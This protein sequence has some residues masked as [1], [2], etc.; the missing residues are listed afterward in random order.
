MESLQNLWEKIRTN[1]IIYAKEFWYFISSVLFL[2]NFGAMIGVASLFL[3]F[4]FWWM[5]CYTMHGDTVEVPDYT[6]LTIA[7]AL[8]HDDNDLFR[9]ELD[10]AEWKE[11]QIGGIIIEQSPK[12]NERVKENR[13]V[14]LTS[15]AFVPPLVQL[16]TLKGSYSFDQ[17]KRKLRSLNINLEI[18]ETRFDAKQDPNTIIHL[19]FDD[20]IISEEDLDKGVDIPKG[21]I[22]KCLVTEKGAFSVPIPN[23]VC[24]KLSEAEF[25]LL[26]S[27]LKLESI[28]EDHTVYDSEN[29]Y[30]YKQSPQYDASLR[31][32]KAAAVDLYITQGVP[33]G[34]QNI[35]EN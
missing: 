8:D 26:N 28:H 9:I 3:L 17:Y 14:Y 34:C 6:N 25:I 19:I 2:K 33:E 23:L 35:I 21:S 29:A 24:Q 1:S 10:S 5:R 27:G 31:L 32:P 4:T 11:D 18:H 13:I 22:V 7:E 20:E 30:V 15:S 12:P 16:P